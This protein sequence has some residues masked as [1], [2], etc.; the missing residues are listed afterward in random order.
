MTLYLCRSEEMRFR[1]PTLVEK[2]SKSGGKGLEIDA[3]IHVFGYYYVQNTSKG[4][5]SLW[6]NF[7]VHNSTES[8]PRKVREISITLTTKG[9][10][11]V[12]NVFHYGDLV[13]KLLG[14]EAFSGLVV[15]LILERMPLD[16]ELDESLPG[17]HWD[18]TP[19]LQSAVPQITRAPSPPRSITDTV[20]TTPA[21]SNNASL[22]SRI[23]AATDL[24]RSLLGYERASSNAM[25]ASSPDSNVHSDGR[26]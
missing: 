20:E 1:A 12:P 7:D 8:P 4:R 23:T 13:E 17:V 26:C 25:S 14:D 24:V 18:L 6:L 22:G 16:V 9:Q 11:G 21:R 10:P 5:S 15:G 3:D 19:A 2:V